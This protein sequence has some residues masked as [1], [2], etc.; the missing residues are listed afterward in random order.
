MKK[1]KKPQDNRQKRKAS[2][3][4]TAD[5]YTNQIPC[6]GGSLHKK[7][8]KK[9][10]GG[11]EKDVLGE[12]WAWHRKTKKTSLTTTR[13]C[14][15]EDGGPEKSDPAFRR[16]GPPITILKRGE[17]IPKEGGRSIPE[18][19]EKMNSKKKSVPARRRKIGPGKK[20][21]YYFSRFPLQSKKRKGGERPFVSTQKGFAGLY[22]AKQK[23]GKTKKKLGKTEREENG[24]G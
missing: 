20:S 14:G 16:Q 3:E 9:K 10:K 15:R 2:I 8:Q 12:L 13:K 17:P 18:K 5:T 21:D 24:D 19:Q 7:N 23:R 4:K 22:A 11:G 6:W 1:T